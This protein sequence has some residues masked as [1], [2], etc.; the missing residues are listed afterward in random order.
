[1]FVGTGRDLSLHYFYI[2][3]SL[4]YFPQ[5]LVV[6]F[7]FLIQRLTSLHHQSRTYARPWLTCFASSARRI[8]RIPSLR[9]AIPAQ[10]RT[11]RT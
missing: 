10:A 5:A 3:K 6:S 4:G 7:S 1:M 11:I 2:K 8:F 9:W